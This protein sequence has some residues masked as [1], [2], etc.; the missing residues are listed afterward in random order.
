MRP[1][2]RRLSVSGTAKCGRWGQLLLHELIRALVYRLP[3]KVE[4][5]AALQLGVVCMV[6]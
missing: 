6:P 2:V 5:A 3:L 1:S 4:Q